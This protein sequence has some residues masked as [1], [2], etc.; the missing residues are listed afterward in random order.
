MEIEF[1][2]Y[3][4]FSDMSLSEIAKQI[5]VSRQ[6]C[7]NWIRRGT[8]VYVDVD[9]NNFNDINLVFRVNCIYEKPDA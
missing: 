9:P 2:R 7:D 3:V 8:P 1:K 5:C 4:A 6:N